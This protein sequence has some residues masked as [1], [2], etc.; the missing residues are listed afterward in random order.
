MGG[1]TNAELGFLDSQVSGTRTDTPPTEFFNGDGTFSL[2]T[3]MAPGVGELSYPEQFHGNL[4]S[5]DIPLGNLN[6]QGLG[7]GGGVSMNLNPA[8]ESLQVTVDVGAGLRGSLTLGYSLTEGFYT[9]TNGYVSVDTGISA[10][11]GGFGVGAGLS[12]GFDEDVAQAGAFID[13]GV[14]GFDATAH[15]DISLTPEMRQRIGERIDRSNRI[16]A[17]KNSFPSGY[18]DWQFRPNSPGAKRFEELL[19]KVNFDNLGDGPF[20]VLV[21]PAGGGG[22]LNDDGPRNGG[23][24]GGDQAGGGGGGSNSGS[25]GGGYSG[26]SGTGG[27]SQSGSGYGGP[28]GSQSGSSGGYGDSTGSS[29]PSSR[30]NNGGLSSGGRY[31]NTGNNPGNPNAAGYGGPYSGGSSGSNNGGLSDPA[32]S[33]EPHTADEE[34]GHTDLLSPILLDL[35]GNGIELTQLWQ[36]TQ[37]IDSGNDGLL[38]RT[39][40]AGVGDGVLFFDANGDGELSETREYVFSE[41]DPTAGSDIEALRA[42]F[43]TNGD[44]VLDAN[45]D[46]WANFR[47]QVTNADGTTSS[48]TLASLGVTSIDLTADATRIEFSDG[49]V[50]DGQT[51]FTRSDGSTGTVGS[52]VLVSERAGYRLEEAVSTDGSGN[53]VSVQTGYAASGDVAFVIRSVT[54]PSGASVTNFFDDDGDGVA[55]RVQTIDTVTQGN[56][57]RVETVVN[58]VGSDVSTGI[59]AS[60]VVTTRS[61]DGSS[62][63]IE[64]DSTGGGWYDQTEVQT[65]NPEGSRTVVI[66]DLAKDGSVIRSS[67]ETVSIDGQTR[68]DAVDEDGDS[69]TDVTETHAI[70]TDGAGIRTEVTT[71]TNGDGSLRSSVTEVTSADGRTRTVTRDLDG[72]GTADVTE[73]TVITVNGDGS[74]SSSFTVTNPDASTRRSSTQTQSDDALTKTRTEDVD[75]DGDIDVTTVDETVI[76]PDGSRLNTI[77]VTNT[78]GSIRSM[79]KVTLGAD[80]VTSETWVDLDQDGT[81]DA[82]DLI[83]QVSVDGTTQER[84]SITWDR[85]SDGTIVGKTTSVTSADGLDIQTTIDADGDGDTDT[86]VSDI[87]TVNGAGVAARVVETRNQ[88]GTLRSKSETITS[89]D[90]LT[91]TTKLDRDGD[92]S[93]DGQSVNALVLGGDDSVTRT[94]SD[95]AGD[96]TTLMGQVTT[97]ESADRRTNTV[98]RDANGDGHTDSVS[99]S[100]EALDGSIVA[101]KTE[102]YANGAVAS[103]SESSISA[104][105]L[106]STTTTDRD[107]DL[108][109]ETAVTDTMVLNSDGSRT[110]SV[111]VKNGD[112]TD[113]SLTITTVSDDALSTTV[114]TDE[115]G[116]GIFERV[117]TST[118]V[119]NADG[120]TTTTDQTRAADTSLLS[121]SR[122][123]VSDDGLVTTV[124]LDGDGDGDFDLVTETTTTLQSDGGTVVTTEL[125]DEAG[126]LRSRTTETASDDGRSVTT[127]QDVNGDGQTDTITARIIADDGTDTTTVSEF[128]AAGGLQSRSQTVISD[129]G[130]TTTTSADHDGD[131]TYDHVVTDATV[132]GADGTTTRT[133][134]GAGA[135]GVAYRSTVIVTSDDGLVTTTSDDIDQD[136]TV[137]LTT[138]TTTSLASNGVRTVTVEHK[139]ANGSVLD[140]STRVTS[141][142]GRTVTEAI[143][144][145]GN[146]QNDAVT[147]TTIGDDGVATSSTSFYSTGGGLEATFRSTVSGDGLI[148]TSAIDRNGD[149]RAEVMTSDITA[150][151][152]DGSVNRDVKHHNDRFVSLG[153]EVYKTSDDGRTRTASLDHDGDGV[154]EAVSTDT[155]TF[156]ADGDVVRT[157]VTRDASSDLM[158]RIIT[159]TSGDGLVTSETADLDGDGVT[160]RVHVVTRGADGSV[161]EALGDYGAG[162]ALAYSESTTVS[163]DGRTRTVT[164][165]LDGDGH[166]DREMVTEIDLSRDVTHSHREIA[167]DGTVEFEL[168]D[169]VSADELSRTH[170]VDLDGDGAA[171]FTRGRETTYLS[172]GSEVTT[173]T[174]TYGA[175]HL[176]YQSVTTVAA[177]GLTSTT[178]VDIDGDGVIDG[179]ETVTTVL[180]A[181]GSRRTIEETTYADGTLRSKVTQSV[182][183]DGRTTA[184]TFDYDGN[185]IAD[186]VIST[187][188]ASDGS[189]TETETAFG[190]GGTEGNRFVTTTSAD[191]LVTTILR[192]GNMQTI[193]RSA[194]DDGSYVWD[195]GVAAAVGQT[196]IVVTHQFD[197]LGIETWTYIG[198]SDSGGTTKTNF[199]ARLD[200]IARQRVIAEAERIYDAVLDRDLDFNER[201]VLVTHIVDGELD[202]AGLVSDLLGSSEFSTRYGN[203]SDAEFVTQI[204]LNALGRVPGLTELD[205]AIRALDN[206]ALSRTDLALDL[207]DS[208]EHRVV[209][210]G[211]MSTNN[212]DV[213]INPAVYER[214][215][216]KAYVRALVENLIDVAYDRDTTEQELDHLSG[217]LLDGADNPDDIATL[218]LALPGNVQGAS[219]AS[220]KGLTGAALVEQAYINALGRQ[221]TA[222]EQ[223]IWEENL[224]SGR[225]TTAQFVASLA[226]SVEHLTAGNAHVTNGPATITTLTGTSA[227]NS[228]VGGVGDDLLYGHEGNDTLNGGNGSYGSDRLI[229]GTG[230]DSLL[231][232]HGNDFYEWS[233]G[234][235]NDI[236]ND[237]G[238]SLIETDRLV[239]TDVLSSEATLSRA[240]GSSNLLITIAGTGEVI[241][242]VNQFNN[243]AYG[244]GIEEIRFSDGV[245]W[246]FADIL[247]KTDQ[248]GDAGANSLSGSNLD[249]VIEGNGGADTLTGNDGDDILTGGTGNDSLVGGNGGDSYLWAS[250]DGNDTINDA[251][252]SL[253]EVDALELVD[254]ASDGVS[255]TRDNG[256]YHLKVTVVAT[257]ETITVLNR[258]NEV[259]PGSGIETIRFSDGVTWALDDILART[260][261]TGT[262]G[263]EVVTGINGYRDNLLGLGGNDT[264]NGN[265]GDDVLTGGTGTD[266]LAGSTGGDT[267]LWS[268]GDGN[269]TLNDTG[270]SLTEIDRLAFTDV[271][272]SEVALTRASGSSNLLV[273]VTATGEVIT[274]INRYNNPSNSYGIEEISFSDGVTWALDDI[275]ARTEV[276]GTSGAN[277]LSG[278]SYADNLKGLAGVDTLTG[279]A[280]DDR[281]IG[282]AGNDVLDGGTGNDRFEWSLGDGSDSLSDTG[283]SLADVDSLALLDVGVTGATLTRSGNN[284][285]VT[286]AATGEVI[287]VNNRFLSSGSGYG[288]EIIAFSDGV[289]TEVLDDPVAKAIITG[290]AANNTLAGWGFKDTIYG[291]AGNDTIDG[292]DGDDTIEGGLGVDVVRGD[293]GNDTYLWKIGDGNDTLY[294]SSASLTDID[295]LRL[296]DV[297]PSGV[298]L[299]RV[300]GS[301]NLL[302]TF[303]GT[304]EMITVTNNY[305]SPTTGYGLEG[306]E[307]ADGTIWN[308]A[309][310]FA[311]TIVSGT[312]ANNSLSGT[313]KAGDNLYG[314]EG[315][316]SL[317]G[318]DEDD[319]LEGGTGNDYLDGGN[320]NDTYLWTTG[321]GNDTLYDTSTSLTDVDTLH[322]GDVDPSGVALTRSGLNIVVTIIA[323]GETITVTNN[324][325]STTRGYGLE[326][327]EF[328]DGTTWNQAEI[329]ANTTYSGTSG[330]DTL[331]GSHKAPD[332]LYGLA[333][334]DTL[335]GYD[336]DDFLIGGSGVDY[337]QGMN[338]NDTYIWSKGDGNDT[339]YDAVTS[340]TEIDTL[341]LTD[342]TSTEVLLTRLNGTYTLTIEI[343]PTGEIISVTNQ[344]H[345]PDNGYGIE[346]ITFLDGIVWTLDDI[347]E[348]TT[349]M[350]TAAGQT[351]TGIGYAD[352][353][354]GLGGNDVLNGNA[355][356]DVLNGGAGSDTLNGG[357]GVDTASYRDAGQ[358]V[359]VDLGVT[360]GQAGSAGGEEVGDVLASIEALEGSGYGDTLTGDDASNDLWGL[361]GSD[362]LSGGDGYDRLYG[363]D[364]ADTLS[365][366]LG[367]D[368]LSGGSGSD[369]LHGDTGHDNL[370]GGDG[371][372]Y[373]AGGDGAD[374]LSG[375]AGNDTLLGGE[376]DDLV[377]GDDGNDSLWGGPSG[378]DTLNGDAGNDVIRG[379]SG[380][381]L[382]DGGAEDDALYGGSG[383]DTLVGGAGADSLWGGAGEDVFVFADGFGVDQILDFNAAS[384]VERIDLSAVSA[385]LDWSDLTSNHA[386]QVG[387]DVVIDDLA[388][389]TIT[390]LGVSLAGLGQGDFVF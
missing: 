337:L 336:Q 187:V 247:E 136:G 44:G 353:I 36:S 331:G 79:Q 258:F 319:L 255:L 102:H 306:I 323:T 194:V 75:G 132:L 209:G 106:V 184:E 160:D 37:F 153:R 66:S 238:T 299:T 311:N 335:Y 310:I 289:T 386:S 43:D 92:G 2:G 347:V 265:S 376:D 74:T 321:D 389:N 6:L 230:D 27:G 372:D 361:A 294:D 381:D 245:T 149:G 228:L 340:L 388:G 343:V 180:N 213:I 365:G 249:D 380:D 157:Q 152:E 18:D 200:D 274:V 109:N 103:R 101:T 110:R 56:G 100:V 300:S 371:F 91:V 28:S 7:V 363:G 302:I 282:G 297:D 16:D 231:G 309:D 69:T 108:L 150:L 367:G 105:G 332:N 292:N 3:R 159:T 295:M 155:T 20:Y 72:D 308:Q 47:V 277:A 359:V 24:G 121:Q 73:A 48:V 278:T 370:F 192:A 279:G 68:S 217:L 374:T 176:G 262:G 314:L 99:S 339:I 169:H 226:Q 384:T 320:G 4:Q 123:V 260:I 188:R 120:S 253:T 248:S 325:H 12:A 39:A 390:L 137:D 303:L 298:S 33:N 40:W 220:L 383:E 237:A 315:N 229:G 313:N 385:I 341:I 127:E 173:I 117:A 186:Q 25:S 57:T 133:V 62:V 346:R 175:T 196:N 54:S 267:Y 55:D 64:R 23:G 114:E 119:L 259:T 216:D 264:L 49:S 197:A 269:D 135:D 172:D 240:S 15:V 288:T 207:A 350:G 382:L 349:V 266:S 145:D 212:F 165:D 84:T 67:T 251:G 270:T 276:T 30:P 178:T 70:S 275:L 9:E 287:T 140:M 87:T 219:S 261:V 318:Y 223:S 351:L 83:K 164:V 179:T 202:Q 26:G 122:T 52:A 214:S 177:D 296:A 221:P 131:G 128:S 183:A 233:K 201:E 144:A 34:Q 234:D 19:N 190:E 162:N 352:N 379:E 80:K 387:A 31:T 252:S 88:D 215:L 113:R 329:F 360:T 268:K 272:S 358:G 166:A 14:I 301:S 148:R 143:D 316:D 284:L 168:V 333:G 235:G 115:D 326:A 111:E 239:L 263:N 142:D 45:D 283:T 124:S 151:G 1:K 154:F 60:R 11:V 204:Y 97:Y 94:V 167:F 373:L 334:N 130:L 32:H 304:G 89:A 185:G 364:G 8:R 189:V 125:R 138:T 158:T 256:T 98:T 236:L 225:I 280:G 182:S 324:F 61:V 362:N 85:N 211:H 42:V 107:G 59:T 281:L 271:T 29:G 254:I 243:P 76:N 134:S 77:T 90:G 286:I 81:F 366:G 51:T 357:A 156:E 82:T 195:N 141:A 181:D 5:Q 206:G 65:T 257:D 210:N 290:T 78:D 38:H 224:S 193:T 241:T 116:D 46:E 345:D 218:L 198:S 13:A 338:G 375:G 344:F 112:G 205:L 58:R 246:T 22:G 170:G 71:L 348:R 35:N 377:F 354:F 63:T 17:L 93:F 232:G 327:I 171:E 10:G 50:I 95:Y 129:D 291:D 191:G 163:A 208:A 126:V 273:T 222:E 96:G 293:N 342:V 322:L 244:Y 250:G 199:E 328:A 285:I 317:Y 161:S 330:N 118:T 21:L 86:S 307:F 356:D 104:N 227:N 369:Q 312:S 378:N 242:V 53:R 368:L 203:M 147:V 174:E 355:G 146:G 139:A 305:H 41:W